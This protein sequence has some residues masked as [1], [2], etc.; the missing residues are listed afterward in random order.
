[1]EPA[2][3]VNETYLRLVQQRTVNL[4]DGSHFLGLAGMTMR[5][6]LIDAARRRHATKRPRHGVALDEVSEETTLP[7]MEQ[8][9]DTR[10]AFAQVAASH[11]RRAAIVRLRIIAGLSVREIAARLRVSEA[12]VKRELASGLALLERR[13]R[14][15]TP[16]AAAAAAAVD[17]PAH[18]AGSSRASAT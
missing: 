2:A 1:M 17:V 5:R 10:R 14:G 8:R 12:T 3:L 16:D 6:V 13:L 15:R 18:L 11:P 9:T 7:D 4:V